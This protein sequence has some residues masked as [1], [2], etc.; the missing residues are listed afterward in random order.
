MNTPIPGVPPWSVHYSLLQRTPA[1]R[2]GPGGVLLGC[3][4]GV[5]R[6]LAAA[7]RGG[8]RPCP[9]HRSMSGLARPSRRRG[10]WKHQVQNRWPRARLAPASDRPPSRP[11]LHCTPRISI[12]QLMRV[13]ME[14]EVSKGSTRCAWSYH[15]NL[16]GGISHPRGPQSLGSPRADGARPPSVVRRR[17]AS[18]LP[19]P[20]ATHPPLHHGQEMRALLDP[21][22]RVLSYTPARRPGDVALPGPIEQGTIR[23]LATGDEGV[24]DPDDLTGVGT[25]FDRRRAFALL[26]QPIDQDCPPDLSSRVVREAGARWPALWLA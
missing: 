15:A 14:E 17:Q 23:V 3:V 2:A 26:R 25:G 11:V 19:P 18:S 13:N 24:P 7:S 4:I 9:A 5:G 10:G 16:A 20:V 8:H 22:G 12:A 1:D 6:R 21:S